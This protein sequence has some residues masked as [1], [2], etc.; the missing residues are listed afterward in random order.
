MTKEEMA[1]AIDAAKEKNTVV[2]LPNGKF[3]GRKQAQA[4]LY[5]WSRDGLKEAEGAF[6]DVFGSG[7]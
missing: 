3:L 1:A 2:E 5:V 7:R 4:F 6:K